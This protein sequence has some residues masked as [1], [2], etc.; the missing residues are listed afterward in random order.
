MKEIPREVLKAAWIA[1][2]RE[3][4]KLTPKSYPDRQVWRDPEEL[5]DEAEEEYAKS[6]AQVAKVI[7]DFLDGKKP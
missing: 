5:W 1:G 6:M 7:V 3:R 2:T 4:R